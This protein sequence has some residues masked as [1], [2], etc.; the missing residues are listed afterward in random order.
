MALLKSFLDS[1]ALKHTLNSAALVNFS[2]Y[3][4]LIMP[5][6]DPL[7]VKYLCNTN[8]IVVFCVVFKCF[9]WFMGQCRHIHY[10]IF[11]SSV[12]LLAV[13]KS[14][15]SFGC[16]KKHWFILLKENWFE[17][18]MLRTTIFEYLA[19]RPTQSDW[20]SLQP[21]SVRIYEN[22]WKWSLFLGNVSFDV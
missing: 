20:R 14:I 21:G 19:S 2:A 1:R 10:Y 7:S 13:I 9:Y 3:M 6:N 15:D 18:P 16:Y 17:L 12:I 4:T 8:R 5:M 22:L 11:M